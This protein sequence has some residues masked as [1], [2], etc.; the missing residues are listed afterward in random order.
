M[1]LVV[2]VCYCFHRLFGMLSMIV[3]NHVLSMIVM[4]TTRVVCYWWYMYAPAFID[5]PV[6]CVLCLL[7]MRA[8]IVGH[9]H[10]DARS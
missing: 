9:D 2:D 8:T 3:M 1:L 4:N 5:C 10:A 7:S 6:C